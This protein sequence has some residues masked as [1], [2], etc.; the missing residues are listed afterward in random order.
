MGRTALW[1]ILIA[2]MCKPDCF[3]VHP[4]YHPSISKLFPSI[5]RISHAST[6]ATHIRKRY[7]TSTSGRFVLRTL[8]PCSTS[9]LHDCAPLSIRMCM[10]ALNRHLT[11]NLILLPEPHHLHRYC[12]PHTGKILPQQVTLLPRRNSLFYFELHAAPAITL[13]ATWRSTALQVLQLQP[14]FTEN[15]ST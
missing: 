12:L 13:G 9:V 6:H 5:K 8:P 4:L 11:S 10:P 15:V 2:W 14:H 1:G 3:F 7:A